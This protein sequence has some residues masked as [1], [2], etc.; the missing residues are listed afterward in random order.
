MKINGLARLPAT[1]KKHFK[2]LLHTSDQVFGLFRNFSEP[3]GHLVK[4]VADLP[5]PLAVHVHLRQKIS[6]MQI[7]VL[8]RE[9][10]SL[11]IFLKINK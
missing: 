1:K 3:G 5:V 6:C 2:K 11:T 8:T 9:I 7:C 10:K 4:L